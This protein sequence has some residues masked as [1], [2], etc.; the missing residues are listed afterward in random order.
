MSVSAA[1]LYMNLRY[2]TFA[3]CKNPCTKMKVAT[4][5]KFK[6]QDR[7][8]PKVKITFPTEVELSVETVTKSMFSTSKTM[9]I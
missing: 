2:E 6:F 5:Y 8:K 9:I 7:K 4:K 1:A 3:E